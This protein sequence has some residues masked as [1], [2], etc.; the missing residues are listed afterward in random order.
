[1]DRRRVGLHRCHCELK[2]LMW[3]SCVWLCVHRPLW[4]DGWSPPVCRGPPPPPSPW[5][6]AYFFSFFFFPT[7]HTRL[8]KVSLRK[9]IPGCASDHSPPPPSPPSSPVI[10]YPSCASAVQ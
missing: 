4:L 3:W 7:V 6:F 10:F 1:M 5:L 2:I 8:C 9:G